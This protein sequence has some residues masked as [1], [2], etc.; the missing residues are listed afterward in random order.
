MNYLATGTGVE[1]YPELSSINQEALLLTAKAMELFVQYLATYSNMHGSGKEK[2]ALSRHI[3]INWKLFRFLPKKIL[4]SKYLKM[5]KEKREEEEGENNNADD[6]DKPQTRCFKSQ[7]D[8][9]KW[10]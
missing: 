1:R 8:A 7:P 2:K 5:L 4:A 6:S 3:P 10:N 9:K